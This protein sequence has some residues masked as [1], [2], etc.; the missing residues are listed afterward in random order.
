MRK[1]QYA[2]QYTVNKNRQ[3]E[4]TS[5]QK[6]GAR[7]KIYIIIGVHLAPIISGPL[8]PQHGV[9]SGCGWRNGLLY[10]RQM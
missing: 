6:I 8:S 1:K 5:E 3:R 4:A 7:S 9:S 10:G 2:I